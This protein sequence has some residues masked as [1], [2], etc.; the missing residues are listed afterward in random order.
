VNEP[1]KIAIL[2]ETPQD[3]QILR[4]SLGCLAEW[5]IPYAMT[6]ASALK[7]PERLSRWIAER[8]RDA[9]EVF[10]VAAGA[11]AN[12]AAAVAAQTSRPV[13][14]VPLDTTLLRGQDALHAMTGLPVGVPVA[15]VGVNNVENAFHCALRVLALHHPEYGS[16]LRRLRA[17]LARKELELLDN[18]QDQYPEIFAPR[19]AESTEK[20]ATGPVAV[21]PAAES[22]AR[23]IHELPLAG[24]APPSQA[25]TPA[26]AT[27]DTPHGSSA[28]M[29]PSGHRARR[30]V[31]S[32]DQPEVAAIEEV[33]D[34]LLDGG[35]V[36]LPTDTVYGLAA[37]A[38]NPN[39]VR[40]IYEIKERERLKP[41][42]LLIH[43]TR[44]LSRLVRE[45]PEQVHALFESHWPGALTLVFR[46]YPGSF[47]ELSS[48]E[49]IGLRMPNHTVTLAV[50]SMVARPLAVSSANLSGKPP[51]LTAD[52]VLD[53]FGDLIECVLDAG[54]T[55]GQRVSTVLSVVQ[56]PFRVLREGAIPFSDLKAIL[57]DEL[58]DL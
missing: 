35:V 57:G 14:G 45:V 19:D 32:P 53:S 50:L 8:E 20:A 38:T 11:A 7:S 30:I 49:T 6:L 24:Q 36:S 47:S 23:A 55:P 52:G 15:V 2:F 58:A 10:I 4:R 41:I 22:A 29:T 39:A 31:V 46:K 21:M 28:P 9:V 26:P 17:D 51:A 37:V 27:K 5:K 33:A 13:I 56:S 54:Q 1:P 42:P 3:F 44:G 43:S 40:R 16:L 12:L 34:I 48:D 25:E 18:L